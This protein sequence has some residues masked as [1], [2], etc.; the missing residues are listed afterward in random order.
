MWPISYKIDTKR[1][2]HGKRSLQPG[3][4]SEMEM[5]MEMNALQ[6]VLHA[7]PALPAMI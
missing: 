1:V 4:R 7:Q 2:W 6:N 5:P 3:W